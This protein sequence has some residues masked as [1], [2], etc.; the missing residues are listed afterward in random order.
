MD[1]RDWEAEFKNRIGKYQRKIRNIYAKAVD[2]AS[3]IGASINN[4]DPSKPFTFADYPQTKQRI[5]KLTNELADDVNT[6]I[7]SGVQAEWENSNFK[8]DALAKAVLGY[9]Y[10][11]RAF[12]QVKK[13][14]DYFNNHA[15]ALAAFQAR[16]QGGLGLSDRVWNYTKQFKN[17]IEMGLDLGIRDGKSAAEIARDLKSY[18][19]EPDKLFRRVRDQYGQLHLS[20]NA[21]AYHP[22]QGVY[23]SSYK[24]A[25]RLTRTEINMSYRTADHTRIQDFDFVVGF[26]VKLSKQHS[27]ID[28]CDDLKGK[29]PKDFLFMGWHPNCMCYTTT[30]LKTDEEIAADD[31]LI[32]QDRNPSTKSVNKVSEVPQGMTDWILQNRGRLDRAEAGGKLPYF[33]KQN[34]AAQLKVNVGGNTSPDAITGFLE[35]TKSFATVF[36]EKSKALAEQ[37][38]C[39]VTPLS[40]KR[41]ARIF[42]KSMSDYNGD[43]TRC[44][45]VVRNTFIVASDKEAQNLLTQIEKV[46]EID[47]L[48]IQL[49]EKDALGY[50]GMLMNVKTSANT[51]AE[52]QI[53]TPQMIYAKASGSEQ[54]LGTKLYN[55]LKKS[56]ID[57]G[58][59]HTYYEQWRTLINNPD[60]FNSEIDEIVRKSKDYYHKA[61]IIYIEY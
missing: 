52:I 21:A 56:G 38:N 36:D 40:I 41:N 37:M 25:L 50:S 29:Y 17:E 45:D 35:K 3:L 30:I 8:N 18:L 26:E 22:G 23:R 24:N 59:G 51:Y 46:F 47:K 43:I 55:K 49:A 16:K 5:D 19:N 12:K 7:V 11:G 1:Q 39:L 6:T 33:V 27:I 61:R 48:K 14:K 57:E 44:R 58:M 2:E 10:T 42:E 34:P 54:I 9:K 15:D 31:K 20:K 32:A 28:I 4:Y 53:N 13:Y 60:R